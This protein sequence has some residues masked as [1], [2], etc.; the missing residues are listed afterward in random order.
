MEG[1]PKGCAAP[2]NGR[3]RQSLSLV[4]QKTA[5][6]DGCCF[7]VI[8]HLFLHYGHFCGRPPSTTCHSLNVVVLFQ[9]LQNG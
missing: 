8:L 5:E 6:L 9:F 1:P 7:V 2:K 3:L 4:L